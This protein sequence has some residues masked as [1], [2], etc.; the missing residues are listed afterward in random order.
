ME[1]YEV[2]QF[3]VYSYIKFSTDINANEKIISYLLTDKAASPPIKLG[4]MLA[5]YLIKH[6]KK[7]NKV[8]FLF[9]NQISGHLSNGSLVGLVGLVSSSEIDIAVQPFIVNEFYLDKVH[10]SY[11]F[12]LFQYTFMTDEPEYTPHILGIF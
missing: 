7:Y 12:K 2:A 8:N 6:S 3:G 11:P 1:R 5:D 9:T 10:F 4:M